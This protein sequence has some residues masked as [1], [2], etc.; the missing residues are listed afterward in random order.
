MPTQRHNDMV[1]ACK[2][3]LGD[4]ALIDTELKQLYRGME[5]RPIKAPDLA[6]D[7]DLAVECFF[8]GRQTDYSH[9]GYPSTLK[10]LQKL[11]D[12]FRDIILVF[13]TDTDIKEVWLHRE[14]NTL[15]KYIRAD[16]PAS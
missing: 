15:V 1:Q 11:G 8:Y 13:P 3:E 12:Y 14:D 7:R 9:R 5:D 4:N 10:Q 6:I 16:N 2:K